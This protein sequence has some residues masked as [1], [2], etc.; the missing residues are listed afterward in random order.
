V[1]TSSNSSSNEEVANVCL[2]EKSI[3]NSSTIKETEVNPE[4]E[5]FLEA[6][7]EMHEEAQ[8]LA[9]LNKK[10]KSDLKLHITKLASIQIELDKLK[11]E[12]EKLVS[13]YTTTG[14][15]CSSTSF[16]MDDYKSLQS[17]FLKFKKVH[18]A[19]CMKLQTELSYLKDLFIKLNKGKSHLNHMLSVQKH[20]TDKTSLRYNKKTTFS[21]KTKFE[22]SKG[23]AILS[24][25]GI[26]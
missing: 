13:S 7:N 6:F 3:D 19:K 26:G 4:L 12:N 22:S 8:R 20:I 18:C 21:K 1:S 9:V 5:E 15:D 25:K 11:Q 16:N 2:M 24:R 23:D 14:Y 10:L 17:K